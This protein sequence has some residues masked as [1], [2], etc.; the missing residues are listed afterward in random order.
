[1]VMPQTPE[2]IHCE[3]INP[4]TSPIS[5]FGQH[6]LNTLSHSKKKT[7]QITNEIQFPTTL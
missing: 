1:M 7:E 3:Q 4:K 6:H 5:Y 2:I